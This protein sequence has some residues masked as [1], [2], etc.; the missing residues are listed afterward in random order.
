MTKF[1]TLRPKTCSY[2]EDNNDIKNAKHSKKC[3]LNKN[4]N[5]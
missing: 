5:F 3:A 1:A 4:L 2:L